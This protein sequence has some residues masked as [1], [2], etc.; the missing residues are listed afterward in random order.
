VL[1]TPD[2]DETRQS[3][4]ASQRPR[5][6]KWRKRLRSWHRD[7]GFLIFGLTVAYAISGLA[8]NHRH[9]WDYNEATARSRHAVGLP[10]D[11]IA[12]LE[13]GRRAVLQQSPT[14]ISDAEATRLVAALGARLEHPTPPRNFFWRGPTRLLVFYGEGDSE[15]VEY[16]PTSGI[17]EL[18]R[19]RE[20]PVL[21]DLNYLHLNEAHG[22]WT[23]AA[24][25]YALLLLFL[26]VS[27]A[28]IVKGRRGLG[29]RGGIL[30]SVGVAVPL[31]GILLLR[32]L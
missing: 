9:H 18:V 14:A 30:L 5:R 27:G 17:A 32:Y 19:R 26:A 28:L 7:V 23:W 24:D 11:L 4:G 31:L 25:A 15:F 22:G 6:S 20:R 8:V 10:A 16:S 13:P 1:P 29:G 3:R 2:E 12:D 21:R